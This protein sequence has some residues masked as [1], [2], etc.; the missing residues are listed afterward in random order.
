[1][2]NRKR[3]AVPTIEKPKDKEE[4]VRRRLDVSVRK[5]ANKNIDFTSIKSSWNSFCKNKLLADTIVEDILPKVNSICF[6]S[7]K[8]INFHFLRLL[9]EDEEQPLPEIDQTLF[10]QA[11]SLVSHLKYRK[12][13]P[14]K[15]PELAKSFSQMKKYIKEEDLPAR[16]YLGTGYISNLNALQVVNTKNHLKLNFYN[17]FKK[18]LTLQPDG[19]DKAEVKRWLKAIYDPEYKE[20]D[21]FILKMREWLKYTPTE[22]NIMKHSS[23]FVKIYYVILKEFEKH[24]D[25]KGI[26]TFSLL[27]HKHG[28][29]LNHITIDNAGLLNTLKYIAKKQ[30]VE[31]VEVESCFDVDDKTFKEKKQEYWRALFNIKLYETKNKK[32]GFTIQTDGKSVVLQM[33]KPKQPE[34]AVSDYRDQ[35]YDNFV[36]IDPGVRALITSYDTNNECLQVSTKGYRHHSKMIYAC[37]KRVGWY[38]KWDHYEEWKLI[39][40]IKTSKTSVME[41]YFEFV[42]PL[43]Q[44]FFEFHKEKGFRN[45]K[46]TSYCRSKAT[47]AK[48][49]KRIGGGKDVKTLVGFGDW[50]Q[51]HGFVKKHPTAPVKRLKRELHKYCRVVDID[52]YK[53]SQTCSL[54]L[55]PVVLYRNRIRRKVNGV[56]EPEARLSN[57][58]SVIRCK[59]NECKLCCMDRDINAS[60]NMLRLLQHQYRREP[61]PACFKR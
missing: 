20:N 18:Y 17:R 38:K 13:P 54:C 19:T 12:E 40:T 25:T 60:K 39:P 7:Y 21:R 10:Y 34:R 43:M 52:E 48:I 30:K 55:N 51:Q 26:R 23:H 35:H 24:P 11:C 36:G 29:T 42:F 28:F 8:L 4:V 1:M 6:L 47:L 14:F 9:E 50:S 56:L 31:K 61:R 33:R 58:R 57:I 59:T 5:E 32:F 22:A 2:S 3:K 27:P 53:T 15:Y 44:T 46:F 16:D 49:C 41:E 45:L 37:K